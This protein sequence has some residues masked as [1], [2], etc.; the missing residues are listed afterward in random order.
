MGCRWPWGEGGMVQL[1]TF[2]ESGA[3][4]GPAPNQPRVLEGGTF[5][6][7]LIKNRMFSTEGGCEKPEM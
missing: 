7:L 3:A 5:G 6:L 2:G 4:G 1:E